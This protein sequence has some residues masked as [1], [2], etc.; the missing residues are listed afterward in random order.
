MKDRW[1]ITLRIRTMIW[2]I[3]LISR[4]L[5]GL[6]NQFK[7]Q[8]IIFRDLNQIFRSLMIIIIKINQILEIWE[9]ITTELDK[10]QVYLNWPPLVIKM[11]IF[12]LD[13]TRIMIIKV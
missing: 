7:H 4:P 9:Q 10:A 5:Q 2:P 1:M 6:N 8:M 3:N 12:K 11:I 13:L